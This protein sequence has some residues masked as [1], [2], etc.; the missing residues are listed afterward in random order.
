M[1]ISAL[2]AGEYYLVVEGLGRSSDF[3]VG[4]E[5]VRELYYHTNRAYYHQRAGV[6]LEEPYTTFTTPAHH[7]RVYEGGHL[8]GASNYKPE[9]G[10]EV[11]AFTGGYHDAADFD[12]FT[13]H[14]RA[15]AQTL[16]AFE[17][18][19]DAFGDG[20]LDI[21]ESGNGL[22]DLLDDADWALQTYMELQQDD[23]AVPLGRGN[24]QDYIRDYEN[25]HGHRPAFGIFPPT[26]LSTL[27]YAAVAAF[28]ARVVEPYDGARSRAYAASARRALKWA[29]DNPAEGDNVERANR[30]FLLWAAAEVYSATGDRATHRVFQQAVEDGGLD[31]YHWSYA[32]WVPMCIWAYATSERQDVNSEIQKRLR[33]RVLRDADYRV[34]R[35]PEPAYRVGSGERDKGFGWGTMNG[36]GHQADVLVR[37]HRLTGDQKYLDAASLNADFQLGC[38]PL[39]KTF[40]TSMGA[41]PPR[42]PQISAYLY[43]GPNKTGQTVSG[44]TVYGLADRQPDWYPEETPA[45]RRWRD[46]GNGGAE[47]SSEFTITE[48]IG[49]SSLLYS[50]LW[51]IEQADGK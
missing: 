15:T 33:A 40:I 3:N 45:W 2:D 29:I 51:A 32:N 6:A 28:Y 4:G 14:L 16:A 18:T 21:P 41:R 44:I 43:T 11:R 37:A 48:T 42:H 17:M 34:Q 26:T 13:Y 5:A 19:P 27:E 9:P 8:E 49:A 20:D 25:R 47:I 46:L 10:E 1:D 35:S 12:V 30:L 38:N 36:G 24:D 23:G 7:Y 50:R 22:P 39:S 31:S